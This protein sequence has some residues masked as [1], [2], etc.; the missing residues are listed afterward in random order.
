[1]SSFLYALVAAANITSM[2]EPKPG[3]YAH[4][5]QHIKQ[6]LIVLCSW[7]TPTVSKSWANI[8]NLLSEYTIPSPGSGNRERVDLAGSFG[9]QQRLCSCLKSLFRVA[10]VGSCKS[11]MVGSVNSERYKSG[12]KRKT[13]ATT[14]GKEPAC[15]CRRR[16]TRVWFLHQEDPLEEGMATHSITLLWRIPWTEEPGGYSSQGCK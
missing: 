5:L 11:F 15:Q 2:M 13:T 12:L 6:I 7:I 14:S 9:F 8:F 4:S 1:M 16:E 3:R 10:I